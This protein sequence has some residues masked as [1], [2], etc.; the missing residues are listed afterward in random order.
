MSSLRSSENFARP[1]SAIL[2]LAL[3]FC[4][5]FTALAQQGSSDAN[6]PTAVPKVSVNGESVSSGDGSAAAGYRAD[7]ITSVGILGPLPAQDTPF[8]FSVASSDLIQNVQATSAQEVTALMPTVQ[9]ITSESNGLGLLYMSRGFQD[10]VAIDGLVQTLSIKGPIAIEDKERVEQ[11][12]GVSALL[13]GPSALGSAIGGIV[14]YVQ[15][16]PTAEPLAVVTLGNHSGS[17]VYIHGDF[18]GPIDSAD[19]FGYR[20]NV[21]AQGGD[22]AIENQSITKYLAS[23]ALDY[24]VTDRTVLQFDASHQFYKN[25]APPLNWN[26]SGSIVP[27]TLNLADSGAPNFTY[28]KWVTDRGGLRLK[29]DLSSIVSVRVGGEFQ[30]N[31]NPNEF[32]D[33]EPLASD[34]SY[35]QVIARFRDRYFDTSA[36]AFLDFKF[37]TFGVQHAVTTGYTFQDDRLREV[38]YDFSSYAFPDGFNIYNSAATAAAQQAAD[39]AQESLS[40]G[41]PPS[42]T[43]FIRQFQSIPLVDNVHFNDQWSLIAAV[44]YAT[45]SLRNYD[46]FIGDTTFNQETS[47]YRKSAVTPMVA[48]LFKPIPA[49]TL[50]ASYQEALEDGGIAPPTFNGLPVADPGPAKPSTSRQYE[51]G[52]KATVG[53]AFLTV[54]LFDINKQN[55]IYLLNPDGTLYD[56]TAGGREEHKGVEFS[57]SGKV[58]DHLTLLGGGT[59]FNARIT[60]EPDDPALIGQIPSGISRYMAKLYGEYTFDA[61]PGFVIAGGVQYYGNQLIANSDTGPF[62]YLPAYTVGNV[63]ARYTRSLLGHAASLF[64]NV[65]NVGNTKSWV[66]PLDPLTFKVSATVSLF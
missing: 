54:S 61:L 37:S 8:S 30:V 57:L 27:P 14:D 13:Y 48:G 66:G 40:P 38:P 15:K 11:L 45:I 41:Q 7:T 19:Q 31:Y 60:R 33:N 51:V 9:N 35:S 16:R 46:D 43:V 36:Y 25:V 4:V 23:L 50:Y 62:V 59:A 10:N 64:F 18:S 22:T 26:L 24:R 12:S 17:N 58:T 52:A 32:A 44:S 53:G 6:T 1:C 65:D 63:G 5:A 2:A 42:M 49:L 39:L 34:G 55:L 56:Y 3:A 28:Q 29:S 20:L 47:S 21:V